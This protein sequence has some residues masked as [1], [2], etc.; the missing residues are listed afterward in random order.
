MKATR[1]YG[2][3]SLPFKDEAE[4]VEERNDEQTSK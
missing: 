4:K 1:V 3:F 2:S